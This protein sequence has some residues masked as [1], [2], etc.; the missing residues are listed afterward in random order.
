MSTFWLETERLVATGAGVQSAIAIDADSLVGVGE[1]GE[2]IRLHSWTATRNALSY[3][4]GQYMWWTGRW[5]SMAIESFFFPA[6][7]LHRSV[8][9]IL[10]SLLLLRLLSLTYLLRTS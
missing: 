9:L 10:L 3:A 7:P 6:F 8:P 4:N 5:T 1:M 2:R